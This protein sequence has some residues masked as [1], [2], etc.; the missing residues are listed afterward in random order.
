MEYRKNNKFKYQIW[1]L[2]FD[3]FL[4]FEIIFSKKKSLKLITN[5]I[6]PVIRY[7]KMIEIFLVEE[8]F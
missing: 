4:K 8:H 3:V 6:K 1:S 5:K 7:F 2:N